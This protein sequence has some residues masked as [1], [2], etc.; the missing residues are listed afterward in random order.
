MAAYSLWA[1]QDPHWRWC[2]HVLWWSSPVS[3][4]FVVYLLQFSG[5]FML[6]FVFLQYADQPALPSC[7]QPCLWWRE[8]DIHY[9]WTTAVT[10]S[11]CAWHA[12]ASCRNHGA[13]KDTVSITSEYPLW[14]YWLNIICLN[15]VHCLVQVSS[16][17]WRCCAVFGW[18]SCSACLAWSSPC[19]WYCCLYS[20]FSGGTAA[21][22]ASTWQV[23]INVMQILFYSYHA[24]WVCQDAVFCQ[25]LCSVE[26][27][28]EFPLL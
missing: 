19:W 18:N 8:S 10:S 6:Y 25:I 22:K 23:L 1:L 3:S 9:T 5:H 24:E 17:S 14:H 28:S 16:E 26:G 2:A 21:A 11:S 20:W 27:C 13:L 15:L 12:N 4:H 7:D